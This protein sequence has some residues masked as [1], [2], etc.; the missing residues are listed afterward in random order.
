MGGEAADKERAVREKRT[1]VE[2]FP[3]KDRL[4]NAADVYHLWV[5]DKKYHLPFGIHPKEYRPA[6]NRGYSMTMGELQELQEYYKE[7]GMN[8]EG[9]VHAEGRS[10]EVQ[11]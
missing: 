6:I 9:E 5:F 3:P 7:R 2:V 8:G 4:I 11:A 10:G 1:A